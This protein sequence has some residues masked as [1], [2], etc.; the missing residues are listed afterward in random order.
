MSTA[1]ERQRCGVRRNPHTFAITDAA[2]RDAETLR[3]LVTS[4]NTASNVRADSAYRSK[5]QRGL[6]GRRRTGLALSSQETKGQVDAEANPHGEC[7][8][9]CRACARLSR[10]RAPEGPD[11]TGH[12]NHRPDPRRGQDRSRRQSSA[13]PVPR[14]AAD[15]RITAPAIQETQPST[16]NRRR[17]QARL[18]PPRAQYATS[19]FKSSKNAGLIEVSTFESS[20]R[21]RFRT[22]LSARAFAPLPP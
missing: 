9:I 2:C 3:D 15:E 14:K 4:E 11:G 7:Q 13:L 20:A 5:G 18:P 6:V 8:N 22:R 19:R 16:E 12:P 17:N 1:P 10:F 21:S